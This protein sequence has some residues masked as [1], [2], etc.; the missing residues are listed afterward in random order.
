M[1][2]TEPSTRYI[3]TLYD[4]HD[5]TIDLFA[6][7]A[8]DFTAVVNHVSRILVDREDTHTIRGISITPEH[9]DDTPEQEGA[10]PVGF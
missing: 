4:E 5:E 1:T 2:T 9:P 8:P 10:G 3:V 6:V 7:T